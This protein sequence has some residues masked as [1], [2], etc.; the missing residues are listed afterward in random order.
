MLISACMLAHGHANNLGEVKLN[1]PWDLISCLLGAVDSV[2]TLDC[3]FF[4]LYFNQAQYTK[5]EA[6]GLSDKHCV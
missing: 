4:P 5:Q 2:Q 3:C 6:V 1:F